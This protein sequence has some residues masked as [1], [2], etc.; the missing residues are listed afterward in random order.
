MQTEPVHVS[1]LPP[2]SNMRARCAKCGGGP[3][4]WVIFCRDDCSVTGGAHFHRRCER[5]GYRWIEQ[6][7]ERRENTPPAAA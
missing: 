6:T 3:P 4:I 7:R 5:C 2:F 1:Q